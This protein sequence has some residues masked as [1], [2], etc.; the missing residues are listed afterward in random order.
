MDRV[1]HDPQAHGEARMTQQDSDVH[2]PR[3]PARA[4]AGGCRC[5]PAGAGKR[6][7]QA[8]HRSASEPGRSSAASGGQS[9]GEGH[10]VRSR[11]PRRC[12]QGHR[13]A[14]DVRPMPPAAG[15]QGDDLRPPAGPQGRRACPRSRCHR[16]AA[17][18]TRRRRWDDPP[19][20]DSHRPHP[21]AA[22]EG[23]GTT[24]KGLQEDRQTELQE[25]GPRPA[26]AGPVE[27]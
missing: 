12:S 4:C 15:I 17:V 1:V 23:P 27:R 11:P 3:S 25:Q 9:A 20:R 14:P 18:T 13:R 24:R 21:Q 10:R 22:P 16:G 19:A 7:R 6:T 5:R 2:P 26:G 8:Y